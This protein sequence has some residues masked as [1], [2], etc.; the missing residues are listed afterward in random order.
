[1]SILIKKNFLERYSPFFLHPFSGDLGPLLPAKGWFPVTRGFLAY[2]WDDLWNDTKT[3]HRGV[4]QEKLAKSSFLRVSFWWMREIIP[5]CVGISQVRWKWQHFWNMKGPQQFSLRMY[6]SYPAFHHIHAHNIR[7]WYTSNLGVNLC[8]SSKVAEFA[9]SMWMGHNR[10]NPTWGITEVVGNVWEVNISDSSPGTCN[11]AECVFLLFKTTSFQKK[12]ILDK[13]GDGYIDFSGVQ[14][15]VRIGCS[16]TLQWFLNSAWPKALCPLS[17]WC[18]MGSSVASRALSASGS[19]N[20]F[21]LRVG[22]SWEK[23]HNW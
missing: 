2:E 21:N 18:F 14:Q 6:F 19:P 15:V 17:T 13:M 7:Y 23:N 20:F 16:H 10:A 1:M 8:F 9:F 3:F 11:K 4:L 5:F 12:N 22:N